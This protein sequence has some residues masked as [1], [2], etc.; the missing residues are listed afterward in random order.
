MAGVSRPYAYPKRL[1]HNMRT[2]YELYLFVLPA[3]ITL[4][5]FNYVP[6]YGLLIAFKDFV[7]SHGIMGSDW[8]GLKHFIRFTES[9]QFWDLIRNTV[10]LSVYV[11]LF[12][13]PLPIIFAILVNQLNEGFLKKSVQTVAYMPHFISTVVIV[14]M[15]LVFLSPRSGL[16]NIVIEMFGGE[17]LQF[18]GLEGWF[19]PFYVLSEIWQHTGW[20]SIIFFAA[21]A[22]IDTSLYEAAKMDGA[23]KWQAIRHID[24]PLLVP[25]ILIIFILKVGYVTSAGGSALSPIFEKVYLM[26]NDLNIGVSEV[27]STYVYKIGLKSQQYSYSAAIGL[28]NTIISFLIVVSINKLAKKYGDSGLW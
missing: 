14:G 26:Q 9:Y 10:L 28:F 27:I 23:N 22:S 16:V 7:P 2:R 20:E 25:T 21:L 8:V 13:F 18:M 3:V 4:I 11:I 1:L 5:V 17:K 19:L 6:I 24:L 15:L 12:T